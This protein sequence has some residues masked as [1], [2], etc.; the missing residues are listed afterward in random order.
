MIEMGKN[1]KLNKKDFEGIEYTSFW[2]YPEHLYPEVKSLSRE[3]DW[4]NYVLKDIDKIERATFSIH[5]DDYKNS[6]MPSGDYQDF[7]IIKREKMIESLKNSLKIA[8]IYSKFDGTIYI[9]L[10]DNPNNKPF[11][12]YAVY[13]KYKKDE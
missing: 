4:L 1:I 6:F 13:L 12:Y 9:Y 5:A 2:G 10:N 3:P 11:G 7:D 8:K